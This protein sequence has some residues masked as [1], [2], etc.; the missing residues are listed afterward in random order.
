MTYQDDPHQKQITAQVQKS[1][2]VANNIEPALQTIAPE[3]IFANQLT[4]VQETVPRAANGG[5]SP[6]QESALSHHHLIA[7]SRLS[8]APRSPANS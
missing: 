5:E 1:S 3:T 2:G 6:L 7:G 4:S 8:K